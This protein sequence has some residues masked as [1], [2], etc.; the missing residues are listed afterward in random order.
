MSKILLTLVLI[1]S[2][3]AFADKESKAVLSSGLS[4]Q[5]STAHLDK[6][7]KSGGIDA[8]TQTIAN[9]SSEI[10]KVYEDAKPDKNGL[11]VTDNKG[12]KILVQL[13]SAVEYITVNFDKGNQ[14]YYA[15]SKLYEAIPLD[16][17]LAI[18]KSMLSPESK[19]EMRETLKNNL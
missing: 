14:H 17:S 19:I 3:S 6:D 9:V 1:F 18:E 10:K 8:L 11:K 4:G 13:V 16:V 5:I 2:S 7:F 15:F 12:K